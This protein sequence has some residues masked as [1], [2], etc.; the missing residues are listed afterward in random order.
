MIV[1]MRRWWVAAAALAVLA[2][3]AG[4][5]RAQTNAGQFLTVVGDVRV[6]TADG[7]QRVPVRG[8]LLREGETVLTGAGALAQVRLLDG[9][10]LAIRADTEM[11]IT[12]FAHAGAEDRESSLL[13]ALLKGGFRSITG[14]IG[15]LN[16]D[17]YRITTPTATIGI[18]GTDHEPVVVL[19]DTAAQL[20]LLPGTY[21]LVHS[22]LTTLQNL[23]GE[24]RTIS[25]NEVGFVSLQ[26]AAPVLLPTLPVIYRT[27]TPVPQA[28][29]PQQQPGGPGLERARGGDAG[30]GSAPGAAGVQRREPGAVAPADGRIGTIRTAPST[31]QT[32]P[33]QTAP[34]QTAPIQTAPSTIQTAPIQTAPIQTAPSTIQTAPSTI[35]TAPSTIQT[36]PLQ[37]AP[38]QVPQAPMIR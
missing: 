11:R 12:R 21:E 25:P 7:T 32:S 6:V 27:P 9:G 33:I 37:T 4:A 1:T 22:G 35:Q 38:T 26:G 16:R 19:P 34:I 18:R 23:R 24:V 36:A 20:Q 17:G 10:L 15:R 31:L 28:V 29:A 5:A 8:M 2:L 13:I 30:K 14:L 3:A